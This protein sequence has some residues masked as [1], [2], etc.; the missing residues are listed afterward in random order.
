MNVTYGHISAEDRVR[1]RECHTLLTEAMGTEQVEDLASF[2]RLLLP[3]TRD[4]VVPVLIA[5]SRKSRIEGAIAGAYVASLNAGM[6]MYAG[7]LSKLRRRG[8]YTRLRAELVDA[9]ADVSRET[10]GQGLRYIVSEVEQGTPVY[11]K[12]IED[13]GAYVAPFRYEQP[14]TQGL[15]ARPLKLVVLPIDGASPPT[16]SQALDIVGVLYEKIYCLPQPRDNIHYMRAAQSLRE[17]YS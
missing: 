3:T 17:Q 16:P 7:V 14:A 6:V 8:I 1:V 11:R 10:A 2:E 12:Y 4:D 5:A 15:R 9:L 13:W